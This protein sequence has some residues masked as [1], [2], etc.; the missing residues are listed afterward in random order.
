[1]H[2]QR[3]QRCG[4]PETRIVL[5]GA[6]AIDRFFSHVEVGDCWEWTAGTINGGY[7]LFQE[8]AGKGMV[9][10]RWLWLYIV[11]P[12]PD[13]LVLDHLC[14]NPP[15]VNPDHLEPVSQAENVRRGVLG[16]RMT[17]SQRAIRNRNRPQWA[18]R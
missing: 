4:D 6:P 5:R 3:W 10:H 1:M 16:I 13:G 8:S 11:G 9:A 7:G 12:I 15:C 18:L 14:R 17:V 2:Y